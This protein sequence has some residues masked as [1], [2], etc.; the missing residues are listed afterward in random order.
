MLDYEQSMQRTYGWVAEEDREEDSCV[1]VHAGFEFADVAPVDQPPYK[2][3]QAEYD[4]Q[5]HH[6]QQPPGE[7]S[8]DAETLAWTKRTKKQ[9]PQVHDWPQR[10]DDVAKHPGVREVEHVAELRGDLRVRDQDA[11]RLKAASCEVLQGKAFPYPNR[12]QG[13]NDNRAH[14]TQE[15]D[16]G[17][18]CIACFFTRLTHAGG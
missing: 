1:E 12:Q 11:Q 7:E 14:N 3:N 17:L 9:A 2:A 16:K 10:L 8:F 13:H 15:R 6:A 4:R 5:A 18:P